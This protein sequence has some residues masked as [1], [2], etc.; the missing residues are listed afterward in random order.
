MR[1][2]R[3]S[4]QILVL[5][6][7][8]GA[9]SAAWAGV[10]CQMMTPDGTDI[11]AGGS[12]PGAETGDF[13]NSLA[14][15][16]D[17]NAD[18]ASAVGIGVN[19]VAGSRSVSIGTH[20]PRSGNSSVTIGASS[21]TVLPYSVALGAQA[22][23]TQWGTMA[24]GAQSSATGSFSNA[25][26]YL[27]TASG[28]N[29]TAIGGFYGSESTG[30][31]E[32]RRTR[33]TGDYAVALGS[34]AGA[35]AT[36]ASALGTDSTVAA[37]ADNAVALG[38]ASYAGE[39]DTVSLG[40]AADDPGPDG[41]PYG[42]ALRRRVVHLADGIGDS[43]ATSIGQLRAFATTLGGGAGWSSGVLTAPDY[44]IQGNSY[45]D[46][47]AA[48][49]AVD[50]RL[51]QLGALAGGGTDAVQYDDASGATLTLS[52]SGGTRVGNLADGQAAD[53][54]VNK[55]QMDAGDAGTLQ[56][57]GDYT[58]AVAASTL[59]SAND[60]TDAAVAQTLDA[61][62][63]YTDATA[64]RTLESANA[65][66]D[67]AASQNLEAANDYSDTAA[68]QAVQSANTYTDASVAR[69][70]ESASAYADNGDAQTLQA[71]NR[72][73]DSSIQYLDDRFTALRHDTEHRFQALD[74]R[75]DRIAAMGGAMSAAAMN[76]AGLSGANRLGVGVASQ[77]GQS[78]LAV[79]Y[80]RL[81]SP[82]ASVSL[83]ASF[84]GED[85]SISA[86]AGFSW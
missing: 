49:A 41:I 35:Q 59:Q 69:T 32:R 61:V 38:A 86:G 2:N 20:I 53:D 39:A 18:A 30:I 50:T 64:A 62:N 36:R 8:G 13:V 82:R 12:T 67:A 84:S 77:G 11:G 28:V 37:G 6:L 81:V 47:G 79:G 19:V 3:L 71:A 54:A 17:V 74:R 46:I 85:R 57:A 24:L 51:T 31:V 80:Q 26:G 73:T 33:A 25:F 65:Y 70:L 43:D 23:A 76:T 72:Y 21:E 55:G 10:A 1:Q 4:Q 63:G 22:S 58:D 60:Y 48:F 34:A 52:G 44:A 42:S 7:A 40:H 45:A 14:C 75:I 68:A 66:T 78:A 15:G 16:R 5:L 9:C 56:A 83:S 27:T 29:S